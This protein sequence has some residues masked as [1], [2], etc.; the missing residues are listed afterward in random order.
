MRLF[1]LLPG[2]LSWGMA[3][4]QLGEVGPKALRRWPGGFSQAKRRARVLPAD[5]P[6][7]HAG[8]A[9]LRMG[10]HMVLLDCHPSEEEGG[11]SCVHTWAGASHCVSELLWSS[12][13]GGP[14]VQR[15]QAAQPHSPCLT[16]WAPASGV[17]LRWGSLPRAPS[18]A[19][20]RRT[21]EV[22]WL[23]SLPLIR[24]PLL[25]RS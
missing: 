17:P 4:Q 12:G 13:T 24:V 1:I 10:R 22:I 18:V 8:V 6:G 9:G 5:A 7:P 21:S 20:S 15:C 16:C 11:G 19:G 14:S 3:K 2:G 25:L 23:C